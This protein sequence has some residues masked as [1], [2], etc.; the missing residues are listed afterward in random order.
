MC[1]FD[2]RGGHLDVLKW[3]RHQGC[4]WGGTF[5]AAAKGGHMDVLEWARAHG[6]PWEQQ[7]SC[8]SSQ[9]RAGI[10]RC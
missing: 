2:A 5:A 1:D 3:L 10:W 6:C 4:Q 9:L 7:S 8:V